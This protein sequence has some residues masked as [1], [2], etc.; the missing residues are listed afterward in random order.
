M[1]FIGEVVSPGLSEENRLRV[2]K[3]QIYHLVF[4]KGKREGLD[5][6][7]VANLPLYKIFSFIQVG[8]FHVRK[9][10]ILTKVDRGISDIKDSIRV[11]TIEV[12]V[13]VISKD[14]LDVFKVEVRKVEPVKGMTIYIVEEVLVRDTIIEGDGRKVKVLQLDLF[15]NIVD[16][17]LKEVIVVIIIVEIKRVGYSEMRLKRD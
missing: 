15:I 8:V 5:L 7:R 16:K 17:D 9:G 11:K 12:I 1:G 4:L 14:V 13:K 6:N 3:E 2:M 10:F